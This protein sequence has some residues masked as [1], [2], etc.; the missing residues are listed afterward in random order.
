MT[1]LWNALFGDPNK[2]KNKKSE[3]AE[4]Q[5]PKE[6]KK[7]KSSKK[8]RQRHSPYLYSP[9]VEVLRKRTNFHSI[10]KQ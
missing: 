6:Q 3:M 7:L 5:N 8:P 4:I 1:S 2:K 10:G 9:I